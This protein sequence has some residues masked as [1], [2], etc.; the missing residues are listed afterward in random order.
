MMKLSV[1]IPC[2]NEELVIKETYNRLK[3]VLDEIKQEYELIFINDGSKDKT[4]DILL[5]LSTEDKNVKILNFSRNFGHQCAVTA[6]INYC[7]GD[8]AVIIDSDLQDPPEVILEMLK[9]METQKANVV[10]GV[11]KKR[12]GESW[13]K[14]VTAKYFYRF[15]NS[16]S[17]VKFPVDTGDFRLIDRSIIDTFNRMEEKNKYIRG[18]ISW[19]GYKQVPC[20][21]EREERF[22]GETK[23]PLRKM[24]KF[25]MIGVFYFSKKPLQIATFSGFFSVL[26]GLIYAIIALVTKLLNPSVLVTGWTTI[27]I[28]IIFFGGVQ[29]LTIGV[30]GQYMG[31][32]F[33]E[34]KDRPE[35]I[36]KNEINF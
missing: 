2:F 23:Y 10:Y 7:T 6:G 1:I 20:Y 9:I 34:A 29:L 4:Y 36:I 14:L 24:L 30:L 33:D 22:A 26:I 12:K 35:Y 19:M 17:D 21:Y 11:R 8:A 13:F 32:L 28:L 5:Q 31:N 15:L 3:H 18:L 27:I 16:L 25:A